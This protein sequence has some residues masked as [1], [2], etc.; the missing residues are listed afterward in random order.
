MTSFRVLAFAPRNAQQSVEFVSACPT[1]A[2]VLV[3]TLE[4]AAE[5]RAANYTPN[6]ASHSTQI[7]NEERD[8]A[9]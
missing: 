4:E 1:S 7:F 2:H 5:L 8:V 3:A 9:L 6:D